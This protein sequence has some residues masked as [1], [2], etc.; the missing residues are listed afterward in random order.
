MKKA[1]KRGRR[2]TL[3]TADN[4]LPQDD[5]SALVNVRV[6]S[7]DPISPTKIQ[8]ALAP[9]QRPS[10]SIAEDGLSFSAR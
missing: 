2:K 7:P 9:A 3:L 6:A 10:V 5:D 4:D 1:T 8:F